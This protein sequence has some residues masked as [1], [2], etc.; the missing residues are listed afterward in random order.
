MSE[1]AKR[2]RGGYCYLV[3]PEWPLYKKKRYRAKV[4]KRDR[5]K[6]MKRKM[7]EKIAGY[8]KRIDSLNNTIWELEDWIFQ[9]DCNSSSL[10]EE[11]QLYE[12]DDRG[13][14]LSRM[15]DA[16]L[17]EEKEK[18]AIDILWTMNEHME[19][20]QRKPDLRCRE[21]VV[22]ALGPYQVKMDAKLPPIMVVDDLN[23]PI[24]L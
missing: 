2:V 23:K 7:F 6:E 18:E 3:N 16:M 9:D 15:R 1:V 19:A 17:E 12:D 8:T 20:P 22:E 24:V 21:N 14:A 10:T 4:R 13:K 11:T 5:V